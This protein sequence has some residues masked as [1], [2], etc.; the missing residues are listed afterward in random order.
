[1][2]KKTTRQI[3]YNKASGQ[4]SVAPKQGNKIEPK[5]ESQPVLKPN[6]AL[7]VALW[8]KSH[9]LFKWSAMCQK[10]G[11]DAGN[12]WRGI[13]GDKPVIAEKYLPEIIKTLK[14][15]GYAD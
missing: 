6:A 8:I 10:L 15:Y 3:L 1:M 12:F 5:K 7:S 14:Q 4:A 9:D 11:L 2:D 13:K